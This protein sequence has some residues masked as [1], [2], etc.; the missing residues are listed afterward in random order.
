MII[1]NNTRNTTCI[2]CSK[3]FMIPRAGKLYCSSRCKQFSYY[4]QSYILPTT[5]PKSGIDSGDVTISLKEFAAFLAVK[6]RVTEYKNL[7]KRE[8]STWS[9]LN[10]L[11]A[12][13]LEELDR[14]LPLYLK[15]SKIPELSIIILPFFDTKRLG[16]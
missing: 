16:C 2:I 1:N 7:K 9:P 14:N 15:A 4:H 10:L 3:A 8:A 13:R 11:Q 12:R 6:A 5:G